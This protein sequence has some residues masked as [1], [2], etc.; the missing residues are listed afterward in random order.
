MVLGRG[1]HAKGPTTQE[2]QRQGGET[3]TSR[4]EGRKD[5][6]L[7]SIESKVVSKKVSSKEATGKN[8][9]CAEAT[10][11]Q[12]S[13]KTQRAATGADEKRQGDG[14][15]TRVRNTA[16]KRVKKIKEGKTEDTMGNSELEMFLG[17]H[18]QEPV[19][20]E[21]AT[22]G[23]AR[24]LDSDLSLLNPFAPPK[25]SSFSFQSLAEESKDLANTTTVMQESFDRLEPV[26]VF[27]QDDET[28]TNTSTPG[29]AQMG[30]SDL[31]MAFSVWQE[32]GKN[33]PRL[34]QEMFAQPFFE[35]SGNPGAAPFFTVGEEEAMGEGRQASS[36]KAARE[37]VKAKSTAPAFSPDPFTLHQRFHAHAL[38]SL[39]G[40][41]SGST[42]TL[43]RLPDILKE[44]R[45]S[46]IENKSEQSEKLSDEDKLV[47]AELEE[48]ISNL[49]STTRENIKNS[50][51]RLMNSTKTS[52]EPSSSVN[53][54]KDSDFIDRLVA[55][56][57]YHR[58]TDVVSVARRT[59]NKGA[60]SRRKAESNSSRQN[61]KH[62]GFVS[63]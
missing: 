9:K 43:L 28:F 14:T 17:V 4:K 27:T 60:T 39:S 54:D 19:L 48:I 40:S 59:N 8:A 10:A 33:S 63:T 52:E 3:S 26:D 13:R 44:A 1:G 42:G 45:T 11:K 6:N 57:L 30:A 41:V 12:A 16:R 32:M 47:L 20:L 5:K 18:A 37:G 61:E 31:E 51:R 56:V 23:S 15:R 24:I 25:M 50:L 35:E 36:K 7:S 53:L 46:P 62:M 21:F 55:N 29:D 58:Y 2:R 34:V 38:S 22:S 49:P